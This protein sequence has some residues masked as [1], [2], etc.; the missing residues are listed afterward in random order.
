MPP[1]HPD[2]AEDPAWDLL[3]RTPDVDVDPHFAKRVA[4]EAARTG[5]PRLGAWLAGLPPVALAGG[6]A[7]LVAAAVLAVAAL[8]P[9]DGDPAGP[10]AEAPGS[11]DVIEHGVAAL[12]YIDYFDELV[13][14]EDPNLLSDADIIALLLDDGSS[15]LLF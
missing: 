13:A 9:G 4:G 2:E 6:A 10:M 15:A 5:R 14:T 1:Q 12:D 8:L 3:R 11:P 7:C